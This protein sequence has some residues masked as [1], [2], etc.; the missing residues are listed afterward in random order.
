MKL[1]TYHCLADQNMH[2]ESSGGQQVTARASFRPGR[3]NGYV[4]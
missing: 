4:I 3:T 2:I 1:A